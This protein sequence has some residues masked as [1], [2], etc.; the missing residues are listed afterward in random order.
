MNPKIGS[1]ANNADLFYE[2]YA[3]RMIVVQGIVYAMAGVEN[4]ADKYVCHC[5]KYFPVENKWEMLPSM[6]YTSFLP[7]ICHLNGKIFCLG[8]KSVGEIYY[9]VQVFDLARQ[10]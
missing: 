9:I 8:G 1:S 6:K 2:Q 3:L 10:I 5:Q 4:I 7:G